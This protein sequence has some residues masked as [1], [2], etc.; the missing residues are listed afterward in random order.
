MNHEIDLSKYNI[1]TDLVADLFNI[2]KTSNNINHNTYDYKNINVLEVNI[3]GDNELNKKIGRYITITFND[4]TD[5]DNFKDLEDVL[6][7]E[8]TKLLDKLNIKDNYKCLVVGLGNIKSTPD[9]LGPKTVSKVLVTRY[10]YELKEIK[11]N[12]NYRNV[13]SFIPG[14][15]G[16]TG[17]ESSDSVLGIIN[18]IKPD[19]IITVDSLA[20]NSIT[21][22]N[23]T[24]QITD[25]GI[26]PGSGVYNNRKELSYETLNIPVISIGI[27][28]VIE[29]YVL[30]SDTIQYIFKH[31]SY[32][33]DNYQKNKLVPITMRNYINHVDNLTS[34]EKEK[35]LGEVG[36]LSDK[37]LKELIYEV[38][39]PIGYNMMVT[40]KEIDFF[41]DKASILIANSIN[42]SLHKNFDI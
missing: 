15:T 1:R 38:L 24:I 2:N 36:T 9:S 13:A 12:S 29:A 8:L 19:F 39:T 21:R 3:T 37:D 41:M 25:S 22:I 20:S 10:L 14:V 4:L 17:I 32:N 18:I 11:P 16:D 28:T 34:S 27:P 6:V 31:F 40:L 35:L 26:S 5:K 42:K 7:K 23:K 33:K 30:V